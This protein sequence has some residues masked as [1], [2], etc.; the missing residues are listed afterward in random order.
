MNSDL[1]ALTS[2]ASNEWFTPPRYIEMVKRVFDGGYIDLDPFSS[3]EA[4]KIVGARRFFTIQQDAFSQR[5][6]S[7]WTADNIFMN[8]PY[9]KVGNE[10]QAGLACAVVVR[11][12][13]E[14]A[15]N[16]AIILVN[17]CTGAQW[18]QPLFDWTICFVG[19]RIRYLSPCRLCH[20]GF[21]KQKNGKGMAY[22]HGTQSLGMI[23]SSPCTRKKNQP[24]K[25]NV[26][27]YLGPNWKRFAEVFGTIGRIRIR[28]EFLPKYVASLKHE[29]HSFKNCYKGDY[30][31]G[32]WTCE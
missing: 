21:P 8:P 5:E 23:P 15:I 24:T 32:K 14:E 25:D 29:G 19:H 17:S 11:A 27:V 16:E 10:S 9:G 2:S 20:A 28:S 7:N 22:H 3:E 4:N 18:F 13:W 31:L 12:Y 26:F 1:Q 30:P 6:W